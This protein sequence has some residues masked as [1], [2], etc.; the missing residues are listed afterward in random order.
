MKELTKA[1]E[2]I[3][4]TI[5]RLEDNAYGVAIKRNIQF[6]E[7]L[8]FKKP[9]DVSERCCWNC[10][11]SNQLIRGFHLRNYDSVWCKK[12][13]DTVDL[14]DLCPAWKDKSTSGNVRIA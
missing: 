8:S 10:Q 4:L 3:L 1:E 2:L 7:D 12:E 13:M 14:R 6:V 9:I 11:W 5:Q